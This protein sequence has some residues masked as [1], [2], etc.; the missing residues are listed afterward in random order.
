LIR[1]NKKK[2][3][4]RRSLIDSFPGIFAD[5]VDNSWKPS[6]VERDQ[7][8]ELRNSLRR[9]SPRAER[10]PGGKKRDH[11]RG[12]QK[13][14]SLGRRPLASGSAIS[15]RKSEPARRYGCAAPGVG[16]G[17]PA[18]RFLSSAAL[19]VACWRRSASDFKLGFGVL[20]VASGWS[21]REQAPSERAHPSKQTRRIVFISKK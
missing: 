10:D 15:G 21:D 14:N 16:A 12:R 9:K 13:T 7:A 3:K 18:A 4:N 8:R 19:A 20:W 11:L 1:V 17:E 6:A 2:Q 5:V